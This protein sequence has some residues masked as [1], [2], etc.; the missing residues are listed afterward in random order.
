MAGVPNPRGGRQVN[1]DAVAR[2]MKGRSGVHP[3]GEGSC[4]YRWLSAARGARRR[5]L[6][7][8]SSCGCSP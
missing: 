3:G 5:R 4:D 1:L 2:R 8:R 6:R 7:A